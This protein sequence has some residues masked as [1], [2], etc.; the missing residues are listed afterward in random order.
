MTAGIMRTSVT[1]LL[2]STLVLT[3]CSTNLN[4][5]NWFGRSSSEAPAPV[6]ENDNP[7]I[8]QRTGLF[9]RQRNAEVVYPG[10]PVETISDLIVE[11]VPGGAIIRATGIASVQGVYD[12]RLTPANED[13]KAEDGVLSYRL[14]GIRRNDVARTGGPA[15]REVTA[16][17]K[18][19]D[20]TLS[21]VRSIRV[22]GVTNA[23]V[24][25]R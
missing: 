5:L 19:T 24:T 20:Q 4:P 12:V 8:P 2:V 18:V 10:S 22:E 16:A 7:L 21:G 1:A 14:E 15:T 3:G 6:A 25:R 13:E 9:A 11:R 17:R 23:Q